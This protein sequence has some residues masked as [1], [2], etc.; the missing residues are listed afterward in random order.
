VIARKKS[1][2]SVFI[3]SFDASS[4]TFRAGCL[5]ASAR[6]LK[7][8]VVSTFGE[9]QQSIAYQLVIVNMTKQSKQI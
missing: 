7:P 1:T 8:G 9:S 5:A 6:S 2:Y 4:A 3:P